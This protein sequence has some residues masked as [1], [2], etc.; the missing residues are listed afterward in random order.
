MTL[1]QLKAGIETNARLASEKT[2]ELRK[3]DFKSNLKEYKRV[4]SLKK[5]YDKK[6][7]AC[8]RELDRRLEQEQPSVTESKSMQNEFKTRFEAIINSTYDRH[9]FEPFVLDFRRYL[10]NKI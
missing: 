9:S 4:E 8:Q 2:I 7:R 10:Q 5:D 3:V 1:S 6:S